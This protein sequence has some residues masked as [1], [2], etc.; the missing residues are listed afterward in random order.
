MAVHSLAYL[1][2]AAKDP[3]TWGAFAE[4]LI[5]ASVI[6]EPED[7]E[8][9]IRLDD[10]PFRLGVEKS[11][12][13]DGALRY[14]GFQCAN[15]TALEATRQALIA[16]GA[17][18]EEAPE[19][20]RKERR[21]EALLLTH[22]PDGN[23]VEIG[24]G[25][26]ISLQT[27]QAGVVQRGASALGH[28]VLRSAHWSESQRFYQEGLGF[29]VSDYIAFDHGDRHLSV[30]FM[31][32]QDG[33]HHTV[34]LVDGGVGISHI[35]LEVPDLDAVGMALDRCRAA[36]YRLRMELGRHTNDLMTSFYA[37]SPNGVPVEIG[38]GGVV[39]NPHAWVVR[40]Y[41]RPSLW[42]HSMEGY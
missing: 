1:G 26:P 14:L 42:G 19:T 39:V 5:G 10:A 30:V 34:A 15:R 35:M 36:G 21:A 2:M 13:E 4:C 31:H 33:R 41:D 3:L 27:Y 37:Y 23:Q 7:K 29:G 25:L 9:R 40:R 38:C 11:E 8:S 16:V 28:V 20:L 32:C 12:D 22:D 18:V 6:S 17:V 24:F